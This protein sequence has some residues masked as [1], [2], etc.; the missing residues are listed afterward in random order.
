MRNNCTACGYPFEFEGNC[1]ACH[2]SPIPQM[3]SEYI[4]Q[5]MHDVVYPLDRLRILQLIQKNLKDE[6]QYAG[7]QLVEYNRARYK[8]KKE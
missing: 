2:D 4:N 1:P 5:A 7:Q 8:K 6:I 3:V